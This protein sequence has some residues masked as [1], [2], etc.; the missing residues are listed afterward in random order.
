MSEKDNVV[1]S[2]AILKLGDHPRVSSS[3]NPL[4][5]VHFGPHTPTAG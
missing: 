3:R 2:D 4:Q 1:D 5:T